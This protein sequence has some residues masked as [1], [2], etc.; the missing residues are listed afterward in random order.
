MQRNE[1]IFFLYIKKE[2]DEEKSPGEEKRDYATIPFDSCYGWE[3]AKGSPSS[4]RPGV[5][6]LAWINL[7]DTPYRRTTVGSC[8]FNTL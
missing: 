1:G 4:T 5:S 6:S 8:Q 7:A 2:E 3:D